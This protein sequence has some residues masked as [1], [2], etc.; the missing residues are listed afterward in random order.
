MER[1]Q[2]N[3][4]ERDGSASDDLIEVD[5]GKI[6][7]VLFSRRFLLTI[8]VVFVVISTLFLWRRPAPHYKTDALIQVNTAKN[9][10]VSASAGIFRNLL[11]GRLAALTSTDVSALLKS[12]FILEP[13]IKQLQLNLSSV[14]LYFPLFGAFWAHRYS[15]AKCI[16]NTK[17]CL[18]RPL[19]GMS[20]FAWGG[21][22]LVIA[23]FRVS[24]DFL[25]KQFRLVSGKAG[26]YAL[27]TATGEPVLQ[28]Q[29]GKLAV[30]RNLQIYL[31][32]TKMRAR[33]GVTFVLEKKS[34]AAIVENMN[35]RL[36]VE[37]LDVTGKSGIL[38]VVLE[39]SNKALLPKTLK[40]ILYYA[41]QKR[42]KQRQL[43]V[44]KKLQFVQ[45]I[46]PA[47]KG[48][49]AAAEQRLSNYRTHNSS[50]DISTEN[51]VLLNQIAT[52]QQS[53]E[54]LKLLRAELLQ[55]FTARHPRVIAVNRKIA[56]VKVSIADFR[57]QLRALPRQQGRAASLE[58]DVKIENNI[59][60]LLRNRM[61]QLK[62]SKTEAVSDIQILNWP[63][64]PVQVLYSFGLLWAV[65]LFLGF[66]L[67]FVFEMFLCL[68]KSV[69]SRSCAE[70]GLPVVA[71][72]PKSK[73]Q[74]K[75]LKN[76]Q[77]NIKHAGSEYCVLASLSQDDAAVEAIRGLLPITQRSLVKSRNKIISI[78]AATEKTETAFLAANLAHIY[79]ES[80]YKVLLVD[81][82]VQKSTL[83]SYLGAK[84]GPGLSEILSG[85]IAF[86]KASQ[87]SAGGLFD[88][89]GAG[90][91]TNNFAKYFLSNKLS[92]F[93]SYVNK[94][95]DVIIVC[96]SPLLTAASGPA[97][98]KCSE[99]N[100]L[101]A[102]PNDKHH[103][104]SSAVKQA[105]MVGAKIDGVLLQA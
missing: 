29:V 44:Q 52:T 79:A 30:N 70:L 11:G 87:G 49:L 41:V 17:N 101:V 73:Q 85:K 51:S 1:K 81:A 89:V 3:N 4:Y 102:E 74:R 65:L 92:I 71:M 56:N 93:L 62:M 64:Y 40:T 35:N 98:V 20:K 67:T 94:L 50:L 69:L 83:H 95:Y 60:S 84:Q 5:L 66:I 78:V 22:K 90:H 39:G 45:K 103:M 88:F 15:N 72:I 59:Y 27:F 77:K 16:E 32:V 37:N 26:H 76:A 46:L 55:N 97:M 99:L 42:L 36:Q 2:D 9:S 7:A 75:A 38:S 105:D 58:R 82:N 53:L 104:L 12:R 23:K 33:P 48:K 43:L 21:E 54:K 18:A 10:S 86:A 96:S 19:F 6:F 91:A 28:G 61:M 100:F 47:V 24:S 80:G 8:V 13:A 14:P 68:K 31:L 57:K 63:D 25:N 34:I